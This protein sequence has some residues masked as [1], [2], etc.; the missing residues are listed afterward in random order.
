MADLICEYGLDGNGIGVRIID[1]LFLV[2][3]FSFLFCLFLFLFEI[4]LFLLDA[5]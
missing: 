3:F 4:S 1:T 2:F 5:S